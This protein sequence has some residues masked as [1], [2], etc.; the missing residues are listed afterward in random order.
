MKVW[1]PFF[2][3]E[4]ERESDPGR[5][6]DSARP[7]PQRAEVVIGI[8][9]RRRIEQ[10][11]WQPEHALLLVRSHELR[12]HWLEIGEHFDLRQ[13]FGFDVMQSNLVDGFLL[14][15]TDPIATRT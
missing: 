2:G 10:L 13:R 12:H 1:Q 3:E 5:I 8:L 6:T 11:R 9:A 7:L 4:V 14:A 15:A